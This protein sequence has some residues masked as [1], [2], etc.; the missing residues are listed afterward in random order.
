MT[1]LRHAGHDVLQ[2]AE[3]LPVRAID[4]LILHDPPPARAADSRR[5]AE[6]LLEVVARIGGRLS[7]AMVV[8]TERG[9]RRRPFPPLVGP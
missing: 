8:V 9:A 5:K 2:L 7:G 3:T 4:E 6:K 1:A